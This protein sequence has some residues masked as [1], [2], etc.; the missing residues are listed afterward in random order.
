MEPRECRINS[1]LILRAMPGPQ[2]ARQSCF[3]DCEEASRKYAN[4]HSINYLLSDI[5]SAG[6]MPDM[7]I[8]KCHQE[9]PDQMTVP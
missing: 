1:A 3:N 4:I 7:V 8:Q 9:A 5:V 6:T 2:S